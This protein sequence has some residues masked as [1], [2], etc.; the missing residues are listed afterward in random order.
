MKPVTK[1][2][3]H[4]EMLE[5][6][7]H[8]H[9]VHSIQWPIMFYLHFSQAKNIGHGYTGLLHHRE[10]KEDHVKFQI[11]LPL[12]CF[13]CSLKEK[14]L[15]TSISSN[16]QMSE[17]VSVPTFSSWS[18]TH[19]TVIQKYAFVLTENFHLSRAGR[20]QTTTTPLD[21]QKIIIKHTY[22]LF[23]LN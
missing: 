3:Q 17:M 10:S 2:I 15:G 13:T 9:E 8:N 14:E 19:V 16:P 23:Y 6:I 22:H 20:K 4:T 1:R 11:C 7:I 18:C 21:L 5:T 12:M